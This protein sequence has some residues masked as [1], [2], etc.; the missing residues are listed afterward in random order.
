M[1]EQKSNF[2]TIKFKSGK[3]NSLECSILGAYPLSQCKD[4]EEY[5]MAE[6]LSTLIKKFY[7]ILINFIN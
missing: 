6:C 7:N 1:K 2:L 4:T 5:P 3:T